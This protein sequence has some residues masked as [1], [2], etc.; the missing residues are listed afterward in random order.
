MKIFRR[1]DSH[2]KKRVN[3]RW[4]SA[5]GLQSK[6]RLSKRGYG[7]KPK[8]GYGSPKKPKPIQIASLKKLK[9]VKKGESI[10]IS[11][12]GLRKKIELVKE[13]V[14]L[15]IAII[16]VDA[17][18]F[19]KKSESKL[20]LR[21]DRKKK[22]ISE[23]ASKKEKA[24]KKAENKEKKEKIEDKVEKTK[25]E[26]KKEKEQEKKEKDKILTTKE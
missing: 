8:T 22:L 16:N 7:K 15:K 9:D 13:S 10:I 23:K 3:P 14:K 1:Q 19:L 5:R 26:I 11:S 24:E 2:K 20:K 21:K 17:A 6:I 4:R 12:I 18:Q 25:E